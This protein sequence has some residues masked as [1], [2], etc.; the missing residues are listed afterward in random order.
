[1]SDSDAVSQRRDEVPPASDRRTRRRVQR[2]DDVFLS[3]VELFVEQGYESTTM[4]QIADRADV[5]RA[6][7]FNHFSR[8]TEFLVEWSLRRRKRIRHAVRATDMQAW[9]LGNVLRFYMSEMAKMSEDTRAE[10]VALM[11]AS[12]L[13]L[14]MLADPPLADELTPIIEAAQ[15]SGQ[16]PRDMNARQAGV[17][18]S[19]AYFSVLSQWIADGPESSDLESPLMAMLDIVLHGLTVPSDPGTATPTNGSRPPTGK[20]G[21]ANPDKSETTRR[22]PRTRARA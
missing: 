7:V 11:D 9:P 4:E 2:R 3:A 1:M 8:K 14:N 5:A 6:T 16:A 19:T 13:A 15:Q 20:G 22:A 21:K 18:V 17:L 10:T 12:L